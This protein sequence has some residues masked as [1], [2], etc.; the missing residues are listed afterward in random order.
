VTSLTAV[1]LFAGVGGIDLALERA[2]VHV[3]AAVEIDDAARG[4]LHDR[5]PQ[6]T[7]F[8]DVTGVPVG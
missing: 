7:L 2:G 4:V 5:F 8:R 6:T 1:S 3:A